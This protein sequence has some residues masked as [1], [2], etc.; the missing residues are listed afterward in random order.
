MHQVNIQT[1]DDYAQ[2]KIS[3]EVISTIIGTAVHEVEGVTPF[4]EHSNNFI[5]RKINF[6]KG[7]HIRI[8][9]DVVSC[10]IDL[11]VDQNVNVVKI[12][13]EVQNKIITTVETMTG[14][15]VGAVDINIINIQ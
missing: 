8:L 6:S 1:K 9:D 3:N 15:E 2:V 11:S 13:K 14:L 5:H 7:V 4:V 10:I 12:S